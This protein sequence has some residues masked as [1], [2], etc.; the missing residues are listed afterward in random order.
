MGVETLG[1]LISAYCRTGRLEGVENAEE[2][3]RTDVR[4]QSRNSESESTD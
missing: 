2:A 3:E 1:S 4:R